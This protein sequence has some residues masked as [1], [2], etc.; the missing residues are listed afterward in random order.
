MDVTTSILV[1]LVAL[2]TILGLCAVIIGSIALCRSVSAAAVEQMIDDHPVP[3]SGPIGPQGPAGADGIQG[4]QG[5]PGHQG[6][7]GIQGVPGI[8]GEQGVVGLQGLTGLQGIQGLQGVPGLQGLAGTAGTNGLQGIPGIQG[9]QGVPGPVVSYSKITTVDSTP[10]SIK[11]HY[12]PWTTWNT[13]WHTFASITVPSSVTKAMVT[14]SGTYQFS[15]DAAVIPGTKASVMMMNL[16]SQNGD[17]LPDAELIVGP[18]IMNVTDGRVT[19]RYNL[20]IS[21]LVENIAGAVYIN[22]SF[23]RVE[24]PEIAGA[25]AETFWIRGMSFMVVP[26]DN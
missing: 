4:E 2:A 15:Y 3:A 25:M 12:N 22:T 20:N 21:G 18:C 6:V 26:V 13:R 11:V 7:Q 1:I 16:G 9:I 23:Y 19:S 14:F 24:L 17:S 8:Q 10:I 5:A